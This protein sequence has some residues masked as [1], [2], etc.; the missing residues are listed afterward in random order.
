ML[1]HYIQHENIKVE[2]KVTI[3]MIMMIIIIKTVTMIIIIMW[4]RRGQNH[5]MLKMQQHSWKEYGV[6]KSSLSRMENGLTKQKRKCHLKNRIQ[7]KSGRI[8]DDVKIKLKSLPDWKGA[9]P[10]KIQDFW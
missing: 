3:V 5:W 8:K 2:S 1:N 6:Q 10:D 9:G 7:W 4:M